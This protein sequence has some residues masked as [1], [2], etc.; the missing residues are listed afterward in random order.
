[1]NYCYSIEIDSKIIEK[2]KNVQ[3]M[4]QRAAT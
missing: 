3:P 2:K 1:M 4:A